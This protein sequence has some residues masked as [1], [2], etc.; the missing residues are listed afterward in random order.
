MCHF[1]SWRALHANRCCAPGAAKRLGELTRP[2]FTGMQS[3]AH[4]RSSTLS[5]G[6][7]MSEKVVPLHSAPS[8][9]DTREAPAG[10]RK[11]QR[12]VLLDLARGIE[13]WRDA[14][15][16]TYATVIEDDCR[17]TFHV[18]SRGFKKWLLRCWTRHS[19]AEHGRRTAPASRAT[20]PLGFDTDEV[21]KEL[22]TIDECIREDSLSPPH[23]TSTYSENVNLRPLRPRKPLIWSDP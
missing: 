15:D 17:K 4:P 21:S 16:D 8:A 6:T 22:R 9:Q 19:Q 12:D 11:P 20:S 2:A 23:P 14:G 5:K 18:R 1:L 10:K 13:L 7:L 3:P